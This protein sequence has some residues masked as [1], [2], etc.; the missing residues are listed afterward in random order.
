VSTAPTKT[1]RSNTGGTP[2]SSRNPVLIGSIGLVL[3][4]VLIWGAFNA[5]KLPIIGGGTT[6]SAAFTEDAGL[7]AGDDVRVAGVKVGSVSG[8]S[9]HGNYVK[10]TFLVKNAWIGNQSTVD[11]GIR[12]L[13][14]AK[15]L[16]V[17]SVGSAKQAP[18]EMIPE[19][20]TTSPYD[21]YPALKQLTNTADAINTTQL[22]QA[23]ETLSSTFQNTPASIQQLL[24]GLSRLSN[25]VSSRDT[26]LQ[27]LLQAANGVTGV[28]A[29]R[30]QQLGQLLQDGSDL[31]QEL[32]ERSA[33]ISQLLV[34]TTALSVQLEGLVSD[35]QATLT[36]ALDQLNGVL[37]ILQDNQDSIDRGLQ[38]FA[39]FIR[40]FTNTLG[41]GR[42][43]D[44][45]IQNLSL[46]GILG[47]AGLGTG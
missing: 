10:V 20:R 12:T 3:I 1:R 28:L 15:Y 23:F 40:V 26:E 24:S 19:S 43:F 14:G 29:A 6:Y 7:A 37:K 9:L 18:A 33:E 27:S 2:F 21:I 22:A 45:Y 35:N 42:W 46:P 4:A 32:N 41:N 13:L 44:N 8:V 36:P 39:P 5:S 38:L 11:I 34:N 31:L 16:A 47:T 25:T 17:D 30:D